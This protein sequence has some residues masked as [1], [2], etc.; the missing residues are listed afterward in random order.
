MIVA[1]VWAGAETME[2]SAVTVQ[3]A[4]ANLSG[5]VVLTDGTYTVKEAESFVAIHV[6]FENIINVYIEG[7][8]YSTFYSPE[9]RPECTARRMER[10]ALDKAKIVRNY[11]HEA[12][13]NRSS[14]LTELGQAAV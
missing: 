11:T 4:F 13:N 2:G 7:I 9:G 8:H 14:H 12:F 10:P 1:P 5:T 3:Q 6:P